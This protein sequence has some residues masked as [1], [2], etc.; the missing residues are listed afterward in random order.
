MFRIESL[1]HSHPMSLANLE[2]CFG[3]LYRVQGIYAADELLGFSIVQ[4]II[5]E[6]TL[7]DICVAPT[8]Q[9]RGLGKQLL[10]ELI[11]QAKVADAVVVMLEVRQSNCA[12]MGL[13][14]QAGFVESGRRKGYYPL[15]DGREDAILMD[16]SL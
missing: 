14:Q 12:A 11:A 8:A 9:G 13:Y 15:D 4:Q 1:V 5:D 3:H 7:L 2:D 10:T 16:L 6:V